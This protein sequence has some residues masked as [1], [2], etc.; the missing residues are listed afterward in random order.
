RRRSCWGPPYWAASEYGHGAACVVGEATASQFLAGWVP[1]ES[2]KGSG[3][4]LR[5]PCLYWLRRSDLNPRPL[6]YES[7]RGRAGRALILR[8][9]AFRPTSSTLCGAT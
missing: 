8:S 1:D 9:N 2:I 5:S 7:L 4:S 6:G 3:E